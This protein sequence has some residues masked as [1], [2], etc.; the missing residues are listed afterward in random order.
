MIIW[1]DDEV[2]V[3]QV[4]RPEEVVPFRPSFVGAYQT[5]FAEPPYNERYFPSEAEGV[6]QRVLQTPGQISLLAVRGT[7]QVLG[8]GLGVPLASRPDVARHMHGLVPIPNTFYLAELGVLPDWRYRGLGRLLVQLRVDRIDR[9]RYTHVL[10]RTS[11]TRH[12]AH[13]MY[14]RMGF[15]DIG[16]Y[17]EVPSRRLNGTVSSDRRLFLCRVL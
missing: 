14:Q 15:E 4:D 8:F 13:D 12:P 6:L 1:S 9:E 17:M 10:L 16:V 3:L 2:R 5:V 7:T 11:A